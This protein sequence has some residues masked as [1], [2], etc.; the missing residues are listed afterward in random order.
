MKAVITV[1]GKDQIGILAKISTLCAQKQINVE[2]VTQSIVQGMFA[3]TMVVDLSRCDEEITALSERFAKEGETMG[4]DVRM[5][6]SE[7]YDA[8]HRI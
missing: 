4:L 8:M 2:D 7:L 1:I 5:T 6:R 3:M